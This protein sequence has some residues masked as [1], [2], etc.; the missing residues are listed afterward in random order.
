[1]WA[2]CGPPFLESARD[3]NLVARGAGENR[4]QAVRAA[5]KALAGQAAAGNDPRASAEAGRKRSGAIAASL[6]AAKRKSCSCPRKSLDEDRTLLSGE[7]RRRS[8][9]ALQPGARIRRSLSPPSRSR[10]S[11]PRRVRHWRPARASGPGPLLP[12]VMSERAEETLYLS[13]QLLAL[14]FA[15]RRA[16]SCDSNEDLLR[17]MAKAVIGG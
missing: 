10:R 13:H 16:G 5:R 14:V 12:Y 17:E 8:L 2:N 11:R 1:M 9:A 15:R 3:R 6:L 4:L 7:S